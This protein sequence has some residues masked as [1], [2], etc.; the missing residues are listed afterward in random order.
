M[1]LP[2]VFFFL[3]KSVEVFNK[4]AGGETGSLLRAV[5]M[6]GADPPEDARLA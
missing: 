2:F 3:D 1:V 5:F 4:D 6:D